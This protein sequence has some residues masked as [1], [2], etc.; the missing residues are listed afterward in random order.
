MLISHNWLQRYFKEKLPAAEKVAEILTFSVF[1]IESVEK[2]ENDFL[3]DVKVLPDRAH[4]AL[5]HR[6]IAGE[7]P[8]AVG[9]K[10]VSPEYKAPPI[11][12]TTPLAIKI[13]NP[14]DCRRYI[15]RRVEIVKVEPSQDWVKEL[16]GSVDQR[17][18]NNIVD[19]ANFVMFDM[20]QPLHAFD[21]DKV[22]GAI[23]IRRAKT[24]EKIITL[25]DKEIIL[26]P[27]VLIIADNEEPLAIAGIKGGKKAE[28]TNQTKNLILESANFNPTL[29]RKTAQK[30]GLLTEASKRFENEISPFIAETAMNEL[31]ALIAEFS[32]NAK[33]GELADEY[34][35]PV[36]IKIIKISA[37]FVGK[38]LGI[39]IS[40]KEIDKILARLGI[41]NGA[42]PAERLDLQIPEN[43]VEEIGRLYGYDKIPAEKLP[44]IKTKVT[45]NKNFYWENQVRQTLA[46]L[47]FSEIMTSSF[48]P[49]GELEI[50]KP[51]AS[52]KAFLRTQ[53]ADQLASS[54]KLNTLNAPLLGL[55]KIKI[56]EIG[57]VFPKSGEETHLALNDF[58]EAKI[59]L[60]KILGEKISGEI[61]GD[62]MEI[63][64]GA[65]IEKLSKPR[66]E[67]LNL[68]VPQGSTFR[69]KPVSLYPFIVRDIAIFVPTDITAD[70][71]W[72]EIEKGIGQEKKLLANHY[73][74]DE[75][76]KA[77]KKS[78]A[79]RLIFQASDRT[80]TDTEVNKIMEKVAVAVSENGWQVR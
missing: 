9:E 26:N 43:L 41:V 21:A 54:L 38:K 69:F 56:F 44:P 8:A 74:F 70:K 16:L 80:L 39:K 6:G 35:K 10:I 29:I 42:I 55:K 57:K 52:D 48:R 36:K 46:K 47:S 25:D 61:Y 22:Q 32:P 75:Y 12:K 58:T 67:R 45:I 5:C 1:E 20:G 51:L 33:F 31:S 15:G 66:T 17:S 27:N 62:L 49:E 24:G 40:E 60:E 4:Y 13:E 76:Q 79:F 65:L 64:L 63:N 53:L 3:L 73:L 18:I 30:I 14:A 19:A 7:L 37:D 77:D 50:E 23:Q 34:P 59:A 78:F 71:L 72:T 11:S 68:S 28:V 2:R